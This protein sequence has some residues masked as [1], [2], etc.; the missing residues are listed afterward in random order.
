MPLPIEQVQHIANLARLELTT[1]EISQYQEQLSAILAYFEQI[2]AIETEEIQPTT[3]GSNLETSLRN[4]QI[5]PGL[6]LEDVLKN[7][8]DVEKEQFRVPPVFE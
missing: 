3:S 4:D 5:F 7:A 8:V 6:N 1:E 2:Q